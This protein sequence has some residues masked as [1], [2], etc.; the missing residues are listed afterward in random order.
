MKFR[1]Q[2]IYRESIKNC[3]FIDKDQEGKRLILDDSEDDL[4]KFEFLEI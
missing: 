1:R 3:I 2:K 4:E